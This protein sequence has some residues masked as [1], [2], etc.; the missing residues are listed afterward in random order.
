LK[1]TYLYAAAFVIATIV[2]LSV[3]PFVKRLALKL[4][5]LDLV[6][7]RRMHADPKPRIGGLAVYLGFAVAL[8]ATV[9]LGLTGPALFSDPHDGHQY[10]LVFRRFLGLFFGGTLILLVGMWDDVMTMRPRN[11]FIAQI[12]VAS[13]SMLYGFRVDGIQLPFAPDWT[14]FPLAAE[15]PI[16]LFWYLGMMN[17]INFLDGLDGLLAGVTAISGFF[18]FI[19]AV[20][21]GHTLAALL[22]C[23][24]IGGAV[25]FLPYNFNPS[26]IILGDTGSLFIGYILATVSIIVTAK[27]AVLVSLAVPLLVL[28]LPVLDT[29]AAIVRRA[30]SGKSIAEADRGHFH[31]LLVFRFGLNVRQAVILIYAVSIVLGV[32]AFILSGGRIGS[33]HV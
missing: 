7:D 3:T 20:I 29:A 28:A 26:K 14:D 18:L 24:L 4:G 25:G 27:G 16:T 33:L 2:A 23:A 31:H 21:H 6:D 13:I 22:L 19:I 11:K 5:M 8:F 1:V 15:I 32:A 9:G 10:V 17:A 12:A 30:A